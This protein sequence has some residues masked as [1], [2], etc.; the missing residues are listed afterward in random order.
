[1]I[2][3]KN[4]FYLT[5]TTYIEILTIIY[6]VKSTIA[7]EKLSESLTTEVTVSRACGV[8]QCFVIAEIRVGVFHEYTGL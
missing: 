4:V 5:S 8:A 2:Q 1:M 3:N 6:V 7:L